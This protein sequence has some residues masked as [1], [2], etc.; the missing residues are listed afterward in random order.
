MRGTIRPLNVFV[1]RR[2]I[3]PLHMMHDETPK[4]RCIQF[5]GFLIDKGPRS[6]RYGRTVALRL[7]VQPCD[8]DED[9]FLSFS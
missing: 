4:E 9:Y 5:G 8:E 7:V 6:R 1:V 2:D 3:S